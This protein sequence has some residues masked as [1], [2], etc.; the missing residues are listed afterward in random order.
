MVTEGPTDLVADAGNLPLEELPVPSVQ[1]VLPP[2]AGRAEGRRD[3]VRGERFGQDAGVEVV[4]L[5]GAL[6]DD[7]QFVGVSQT[8]RVT[9]GSTSWTNHS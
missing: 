4:A 5:A 7:L 3:L 8:T 6:G 2:T 9:W 1:P